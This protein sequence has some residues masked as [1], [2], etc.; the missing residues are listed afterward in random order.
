[1]TIGRNFVNVTQKARGREPFKYEFE[2]IPYTACEQGASRGAR[3]G[4]GSMPRCAAWGCMATAHQ[5]LTPLVLR[6]HSR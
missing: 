2:V 5:P 3:G 6:G 1:M 4:G